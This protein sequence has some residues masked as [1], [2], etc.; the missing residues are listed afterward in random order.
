MS[1]NCQK[2]QIK[3]AALKITQVFKAQQSVLYLCKEC[4]RILGIE[5]FEPEIYLEFSKF[6]QE[7]KETD[8]LTN[9]SCSKCGMK[10]EKFQADGL[11]GCAE[12]YH[13]FRD[14]LKP[15]L[16]RYHGT[17]SHRI[18]TSRKSGKTN[19]TTINKLE[20]ELKQALKREDFELAAKL[21]DKIRLIEEN[22]R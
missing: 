14:F 8:E 13:S 16:R 15:L 19:N 11:L 12:C 5:V 2:C 22:G 17:T 3:P 1:I 21:R 20:I 18:I 4:A 7:Q 9:I 6:I 10:L